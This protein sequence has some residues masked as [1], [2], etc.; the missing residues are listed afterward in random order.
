[1][2]KL[3]LS[4]IGIMFVFINFISISAQPNNEWNNKPDV[5]KVN[6]EDAHATL[7]P[8][9]DINSAIVD[10]RQNSIFYYSLNGTWK[11]ELAT[12]PSLRNTTF[13]NDAADVSGW[14]DIQVPGDWQTQGFDYPIYTNATYPWTGYEN[15]NPPLAPTVYNPVGSYRRDFTVPA[16][17]NGR[18]VFL[19][20]QGIGS[21]FYVWVNGNYVG[22]GEDTFTE[23]DYDVTSYLRSGTNNISVQVFRWSDGSWLEDQ[24]MIRLSGIVRNAYLFSTPQVHINDFHYVTDLDAGYTDATLTVKAKVRYYAETA[25]S[26][27]AV[28]AQVFDSNGGA[29]ANLQLG[30]VTFSGSNEAVLTQSTLISNPLKW[31]AEYPNLY[32][33]VVVLKDPSANIIETESCNLG[34]REFALS[35]GQ[36]KLNGK[37]IMFKGV[38]R[39]ETDPDKGKTLSYERMLE[40]ILIMKRFNINAVRTSHYPNDPVW[41]DLCDKYGIY[42]IDETNLES[43]GI[44]DVLPASKSEWTA[45]CIDRIQ[46]MIERDKNHPCVLIWSLGNEAGSGTNFQLMANWAHQNDPTRLVHYEGYNNVADI[47]S[48]MYAAVG[49]VAQYGASGNSKPL[50]LC[51]YAHAMGNSVGNL[52]Q[53]WD[54]FEK[55]PN[56]QG[57]FIWDFVDQGLRNSSGGF[58]YGGD[59]GDNPNDGDFCA[60]GIISADRTLQPEIYEVKKVYQNIKFKPVDLLQGKVEIVNHNLF[61][62]VNSFNGFWQVL[63]EDR[64]IVSGKFAS[65]DIDIPPLTNKIITVDIGNP[66]LKPGAEY[67]LNLSFKLAQ[68]ETWAEAGHEVASE[69]FKIPFVVP[70]APTVDTLSIP[71]I[72]VTELTDSVVVTNSNLRLVLNKKSGSITTYEYEG[73]KLLE[74]GP[75]PNFW[76]APNSNDRGNG[77]PNRCNT[78]R[79]ASRSRTVTGVTLNQTST[80]QVQ[81]VVSFSFPTSTKSFGSEVYDI[82]GDGNIVITSTLVPGGSQL[83]EI[84]EIGM[85]CQVPSQFSN[86][87][88]YGRGPVENYWDKKTGSNIGV[89]NTKVDSMF[90]SYIRPQEAGNRTDVR[91]MTLTD[92]SGKGLMAVGMQEIE[93]NALQYTPWE[94]ESKTH[95]YQLVK[96]NSTVLR[97]NYHQMGVGGDDSWGARPHPEFTM[98][99]DKAYTYRYRLLPILASQQ[100]MDLSRIF[101]SQALNIEVPDLVGLHQSVVDSII[102]AK[103]L[104]V[105]N[106]TTAFSNSIPADHVMSQLP[107][108]GFNV[109]VGTAVN[110]EISLGVT[111]NVALNKQSWADSEETSKNNTADKGNDGNTSTRW[112]ANNG[113]A[114]HWWK[115]DLGDQYDLVG[116]EIMWEFDGRNYGYMI[117][118]SPDNNIW[119]MVVNKTNN[120][121]TSQIQQDI[122]NEESVRYVRVTVSKL[123]ANTWASF[124]EIKVLA[125]LAT[126]TEEIDNIPTE[127]KL[128]QNF[129]NPFNPSTKIQYSLNEKCKMKLSVYDILGREVDTLVNQ[130]QEPGN[131]TV[132][133]N[134]NGLASGIYICRL[135][136]GKESLTRK[137]LLLK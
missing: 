27:Y 46:S 52:Y 77:M 128:N 87:T 35:G 119:K 84:P 131:Y 97:L 107:Q 12:K 40:D 105:G 103:G 22:Y 132:D 78:W 96:N 31:S 42:I 26:D 82:Y 18:Q 65:T 89:Y 17:W 1:M 28:E 41:Y 20:F 117:Q 48:Y 127:Y 60:N 69:Q 9:A 29:I 39:H 61:T 106:I 53:Y 126:G 44:R 50:I 129:P 133:F 43:H 120:T 100:A 81:I 6:R 8:Y 88:W 111:N 134:A 135:Q 90:V 36:M 14:S 34:F 83:P 93:F 47:T 130:I 94:L 19:A 80:R 66:D 75:V 21:A 112:C 125:S 113:D 99:S 10:D 59:W 32:K 136:N 72:T 51:E 5:F 33:L 24:D 122:F 92:N 137:M 123:A 25:P 79:D 49:T 116:T 104:L 3:L 37:P 124:Y 109:P 101:F 86:V 54:E 110:L 23:K 64:V 114:F 95:P 91:W 57:A 98:Y 63:E 45:N 58:S 7:V 108:A 68:N 70:V 118:V 102:T 55:Y 38:D 67:W 56:L 74:S 13:F 71:E 16:G 30:T 15:P 121:S 115:V 4:L 76:R 62:N 85:L 73:L 2:K 11:F